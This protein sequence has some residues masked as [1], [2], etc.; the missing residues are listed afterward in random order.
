MPEI[1]M[2]YNVA[3]KSH[4]DIQYGDM[5]PTW[6]NGF[7]ATHCMVSCE[8]YLVHILDCIMNHNP[9]VLPFHCSR[10]TLLLA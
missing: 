6:I 1:G 3:K 10:L 2:S 9:I 4:H 8:A 5:E 7:F